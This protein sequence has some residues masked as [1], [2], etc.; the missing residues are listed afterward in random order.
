APLGSFTR[1]HGGLRLTS[2]SWLC[3]LGFWPPFTARV[4]CGLVNL[5]PSGMEGLLDMGM[6]AGW[7]AASVARH[8]CACPDARQSSRVDA[9]HR[10]SINRAVA[11]PVADGG[12]RSAGWG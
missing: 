1:S 2:G 6:R 9:T 11:A 12:N 4:P 3:A 5:L 8:A 7:T 10:L